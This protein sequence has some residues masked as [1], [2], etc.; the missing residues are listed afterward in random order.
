MNRAEMELKILFMEME[1][2]IK[3]LNAW[4]EGGCRLGANELTD[5][6]LDAAAL[7]EQAIKLRLMHKLR[8]TEIFEGKEK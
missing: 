5:L 6:T 3:R 8:L 4:K 7:S 1:E 2:N